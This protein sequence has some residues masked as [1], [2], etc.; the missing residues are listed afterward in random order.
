[1]KR[2]GFAGYCASGVLPATA[3]T[4]TRAGRGASG[5]L[6]SGEDIRKQ[7][8]EVRP[9][10]A[11]S[12]EVFQSLLATR[13]FAGLEVPSAPRRL[14]LHQGRGTRSR[15]RLPR[16]GARRASPACRRSSPACRCAGGPRRAPPVRPRWERPCRRQPRRRAR[17]ARGSPPGRATPRTRRR[18]TIMNSGC[19]R[20][21]RGLDAGGHRPGVAQR[22]RAP[23]A[24]PRR[25]GPRCGSPRRRGARTPA[26]CARSPRPR[27]SRPR[28]RRSPAASRPA[29]DGACL[30][31]QRLERG[32]P[33]RE[34]RSG[35]PRW[36]SFR[37]RRSRSHALR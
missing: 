34:C 27:G 21:H 30:L 25:C 12:Q 37:Y 35:S 24:C 7:I 29:R 2:I 9:R 13:P 8:N 17:A 4:Q 16:R 23:C 3:A 11:V 33:C 26:P 20:F 36:R 22:L 10:L 19:P 18:A 32:G 14:E 1:M 5:T 28:H 15:G 31:D 6:S